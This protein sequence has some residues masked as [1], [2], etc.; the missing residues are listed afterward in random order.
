[1]ITYNTIST[2]PH[3]YSTIPILF[4]Q[5]CLYSDFTEAM[6]SLGYTR[7]ISVENFRTPNFELVAGIINNRCD[8]F[9]YY[10][11]LFYLL[12]HLCS[13]DCFVDI[14]QWLTQ[15][16][17]PSIDIPKERATESD[18]VV[19]LKTVASAIHDKAQIKLN[20]KKLYS[21]DGYAQSP[22]SSLP[23]LS[24]LMFL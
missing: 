21:S 2:Y 11:Y 9:S 17:D 10:H 13:F 3:Y 16:Y 12:L 8:D 23:L 24:K 14:L 15:R 5:Y 19:F 22:L 20:T 18:R 6:R 7:L 1:M 4:T